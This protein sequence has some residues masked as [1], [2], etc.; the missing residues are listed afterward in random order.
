MIRTLSIVAVLGTAL[1]LPAV[2]EES[3]NKIE[4]GTGPTSTMTDQVPQMKRDAETIKQDGPSSAKPLPATKAVGDA[5]PSLRPGDA[6]SGPTDNKSSS[7]TTAVAKPID[8][9]SL[10]EQEG[11]TWIKK[12]VYS[13]DG[14]DLGAV[15]SFQ[16]DATNNV[17][18]MH[19]DIGGFWVF[20]QTRIN[21]LPAQ[22]KLQGDRVL[23]DLT[24]DQAKTLPTAK[25]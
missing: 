12:P 23:L 15:V 3:K 22:F 17:I 18:G 24:A 10:S 20:G 16:R 9:M 4:P 6:V 13:S 14:K 8:S 7:T 1:A 5:V 19:A 11:K 2:A 25:I 21:L